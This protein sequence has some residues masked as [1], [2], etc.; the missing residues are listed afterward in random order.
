MKKII[1]S[2]FLIA[3][4]QLAKADLWG[5]DLPLLAQI[6]T[7]T[8]NT[9]YELQ[10]QR[11][12]MEDELDGINDH[13]NRVRTIS[14]IV[15]P[16]QWDQWKNPEEAVRRLGVIYRTMPKEYRSEKADM[17]ES[18]LS[19][20]MNLISRIRSESETSF[21][22][23]KE[24]ENRALRS[25]P[26]VSQK[27]TA[28]GIGTLISLESQTHAIQSHVVSLLTQ[29]LADGHEKESRMVMRRI[30][31]FKTELIHPNI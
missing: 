6:V 23:G 14:D 31:I 11:Q 21:H 28:S 17:I 4:A 30:G 16:S 7:N 18:E 22:S 27:L 8:L 25:S 2:I 19:N 29:M 1:I 10:K 26:G 13:I 3:S 12:I 20:A 15:Q 24:L 5:G 9:L